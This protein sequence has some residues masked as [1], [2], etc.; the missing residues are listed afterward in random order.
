LANHVQKTI[1]SN[2]CSFQVAWK[3]YV[4]TND[5]TPPWNLTEALL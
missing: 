1:D 5:F 3:F 4:N 2:K